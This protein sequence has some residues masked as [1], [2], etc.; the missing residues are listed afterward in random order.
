MKRILTFVFTAMLA[1]QAWAVDDYYDFYDGSLRY[2]IRRIG[3]IAG[4][5]FL[6]FCQ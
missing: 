4:Y 1:G 2:K 3:Q 6:S 5:F